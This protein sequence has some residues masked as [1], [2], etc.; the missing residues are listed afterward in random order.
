[1]S[2]SWQIVFSWKFARVF[3][4]L[5]TWWTT[6]LKLL[7]SGAQFLQNNRL[8]WSWGSIPACSKLWVYFSKK[9]KSII[10]SISK[11]SFVLLRSVKC[12]E[13]F[14]DCHQLV[15]LNL[16]LL[17]HWHIMNDIKINAYV[18]RR[19]ADIN[20]CFVLS[21]SGCIDGCLLP[22]E[23]GAKG[24]TSPSSVLTN[25]VPSHRVWAWWGRAQCWLKGPLRAPNM[26]RPERG[27]GSSQKVRS[28]IEEDRSRVRTLDTATTYGWEVQPRS[29]LPTT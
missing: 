12:I 2:P 6:A 13:S 5:L 19:N 4:S 15:S 25:G 17:A 28:G 9:G 1:M 18:K 7:G 14:S 3:A 22:K 29:K 20:F 21:V 24:D 27:P 23:W 16:A 8:L 10:W 26:P 11:L